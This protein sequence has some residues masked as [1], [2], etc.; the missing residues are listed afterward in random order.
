MN[1]YFKSLDIFKK[2]TLGCL[3]EKGEIQRTY[4]ISK[5]DLTYINKC[6]VCGS[7]NNSIVAEVYLKKLNF[8]TTSVCNEC[9][10]TFRSISPSLQWFQKCWG[11]IKTNELTVFNP[12]MEIIRKKRYE[13]YHRLLSKYTRGKALDIGA[14][15]GTGSKVFLGHGYK[16]EALEPEDNKAQYIKKVLK[17]PV[18][19]ES[20][21]SFLSSPLEKQFDL[22]L[23]THCLEHLDNPAVVIK[24]L[25]KLLKPNGI[26]YVEIPVLWNYVTWS[27]AFYLT[28][29][30]NFGEKQ[31][32]RLVET[33]G[34]NIRE[35]VSMHHSLNEPY[36]FGLVLQNSASAMYGSSNNTNE[37]HSIRDV[38]RLYRKKLPIAKIPPLTEKLKYSVPYIEQFYS[39]L[40]FKN[41]VLESMNPSTLKFSRR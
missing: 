10:F 25:K 14:S 29:K 22:I 21:E 26:M 11:K 3:E 6:S 24:R 39:T 36:D 5:S 20:I 32:T 37:K 27:D 30:S 40:K 23:F 7:G 16:I 38:L 9:L 17:I 33:Y 18:H 1:K 4:P 15:Y 2:R 31:I 12:E 8:F 41:C 13:R 19:Q 34:F 28:H 35:K